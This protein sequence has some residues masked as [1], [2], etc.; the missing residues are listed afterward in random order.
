MRTMWNMLS[1]A[2]NVWK[3]A[4]CTYHTVAMD[5]AWKYAIRVV[6]ERDKTCIEH[7]E[8]WLYDSRWK[9]E[10]KTEKIEKIGKREKIWRNLKKEKYAEAGFEPATNKNK[11][12]WEYK[13]EQR[14]R[15]GL[16]VRQ[17]A[18]GHSSP[19]LTLSR[20]FLAFY[21]VSGRSGYFKISRAR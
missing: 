19:R 14:R 20:L 1:W 5:M 18:Q 8:R 16:G 12:F 10:K 11:I 17:P 2:T 4:T 9:K 21:R 7:L 3:V 6:W 15:G 13:P